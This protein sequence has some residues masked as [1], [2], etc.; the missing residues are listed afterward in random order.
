MSPIVG[1]S[2]CLD[3][4]GRWRTGRD[5]VYIDLAYAQAV[6]AAGGLPIHL[7]PQGDAAALAS[8]ID[9]LVLPGGDDFLP[10]ANASGAERTYPKDVFDPTS[11][12][13]IEFDSRLLDHALARGIPVLGICYGMQLIALRHGGSLHHH[14]PVDLPNADGHRLPEATGRHALRV[15][16][17]TRLEGILGS[18]PAPVNSIH[19]QAV[20]TPGSGLR[21]CAR[22]PDG[23]VEAIESEGPGF[24]LGVQWHPEKLTGDGRLALF[25][26]LL[27][28]CQVRSS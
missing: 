6:E 8:R 14:L 24:V 1:I 11:E 16:P 5:Y 3:D 26:A 13:Q 15:E 27:A 7:P 17:G 2:Q 23:V 12:T 18:N 22:S 20:D 9:A 21:V 10:Q 4:R 19:H 28:G 25:R